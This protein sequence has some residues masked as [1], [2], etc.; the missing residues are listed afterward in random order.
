MYHCDHGGYVFNGVSLVK[1][2][3]QDIDEFNSKEVAS[4]KRDLEKRKEEL[5]K[6][7]AKVDEALAKK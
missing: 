3:Q 7:L 2:T 4:I 6:E 1:A 5:E